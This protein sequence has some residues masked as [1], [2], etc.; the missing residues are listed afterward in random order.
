MA[1]SR[2]RLL[3]KRHRT[4]GHPCRY[5]LSSTRSSWEDSMGTCA[6]AAKANEGALRG[7]DEMGW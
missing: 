6:C 4:N 1:A 7:V 5:C 3:P 2:V